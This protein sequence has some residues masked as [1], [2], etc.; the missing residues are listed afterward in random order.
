MASGLPVVYPRSGG[1]PELVGEE[2][3]V[4]VS[5]PDSW[6]RDEP[7]APDALASAVEHVLAD[8]PRY[9]A[10][11]RARAVER[12]ALAPWLDRHAE[13]FRLFGEAPQRPEASKP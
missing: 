6:D 1:V 12:F 11:A 9:A 8:L 4:G 3:G 2:A 13:L 10:N 7:P 5:H